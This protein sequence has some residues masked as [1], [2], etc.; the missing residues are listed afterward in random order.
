MRKCGGKKTSWDFSRGFI[1]SGF[2]LF[3]AFL[4]GVARPGLGR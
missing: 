1:N 3:R 4:A 2:G